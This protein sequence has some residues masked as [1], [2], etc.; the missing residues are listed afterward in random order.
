MEL[1]ASESSAEE[2]LSIQHVSIQMYLQLCSAALAADSSILVQP[3]FSRP[4]PVT[5]S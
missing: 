1:I 3:A 5:M 4:K 2:V